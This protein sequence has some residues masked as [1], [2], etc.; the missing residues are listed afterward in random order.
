MLPLTVDFSRLPV[1]LI[2]RG[3]QALNRLHTLEDAGAGQVRV[4]SDQPSDE[5]RARAGDRLIERLPT[6]A[7][8]DQAATI[9]IGDLSVDEAEPIV[10]KARALR[11][12]VNTE[13]VPHLC[14]FHVPAIV[15]RGDLI[16]SV[17]TRGMAPALARRIKEY[18]ARRFGPEWAERVAALGQARSSWRADGADANA[19]RANTD[20]FIAERGWL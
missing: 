4:Y 14:D 5:L 16:L 7:E 1:A 20:R 9:F 2:G 13:D 8:L 11:K 18:L 6:S 19:V 17:S 12:L 15:R 3:G 10:A